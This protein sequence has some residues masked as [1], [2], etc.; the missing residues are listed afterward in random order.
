MVWDVMV[1]AAFVVVSVAVLAGFASKLLLTWLKKPL[2]VAPQHRLLVSTLFRR[3][4]HGLNQ[5]HERKKLRK[6]RAMKKK[7]AAE[8]ARLEIEHGHEWRG[9]IQEQFGRLWLRLNMPEKKP[10][11]EPLKLPKIRGEGGK[12]A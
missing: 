9:M 8:L 11:K 10:A 1:A 6:N 4:R 7:L 2:Q 5:T 12:V 3:L